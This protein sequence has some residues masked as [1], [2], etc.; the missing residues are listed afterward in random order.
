MGH[1]PERWHSGRLFGADPEGGNHDRVLVPKCGE[2]DAT[3]ATEGVCH[4]QHL[5]PASRADFALLL[6]VFSCS[7]VL[8]QRANHD[9]LLVCTGHI[10]GVSQ[11]T[12]GRVTNNIHSQQAVLILCLY[13]MFS[14]VRRCSPNVQITTEFWSPQATG[15]VSQTTCLLARGSAEWAEPSCIRQARDRNTK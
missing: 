13:C 6:Y 11:A 7:R 15:G 14:L 1:P 2:M 12:R 9:R 10:R 8:A 3:Q 5:L 4:K